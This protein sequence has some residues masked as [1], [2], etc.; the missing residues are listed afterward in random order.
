MKHVSR[1]EWPWVIA[2]AVIVMGLTTVPYAAAW[3]RADA[4]L[5]FSGFVI[6]V[7][8]GNSY[9]AKMQEG[10][11]G[12]WL[13]RLSYAVEDH[14]PSLVFLFFILLGKA[15]GAAAGTD[16]P[17][18]LHDA[19]ALGFHS[20]RIL[21]G[22]G[23]T[24]VTYLFLAEILPRVRQRR[25]A[26]ITASL[27]GGLGWL[28]L[29]WPQ[30]G[31]PL[32]FYSP[33]AFS[34]LHLYLLP[35][36]EAVRALLLGGLLCYLWAVRGRWP[37][38]LGAGVCWLLMTLVQPFYMLIVFGILGVHVA[39]LAALAVRQG[40]GELTHGVDAGA[41]AVRALWVSALSGAFGAPMVLYTFLL[42]QV[43]PV[44]K[45]WSSQNIIL[46]P[47]PWHYLSAWGL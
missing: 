9:L 35:H 6:G 29:A 20:A 47:A 32:E 3:L 22:I 19:L 39:V 1:R 21:L 2:F 45:V 16:D 5:H 4:N 44:Y 37:W 30:L 11:H 18:R 26:L 12:Q 33:E 46:S 25:L 17:V 15:I 28:L 31:Q 36:L 27:C 42:F 23:Q 13:F 10:A 14:P 7:E 24:L 41:A 43:D 40:E 34:F 8:D 38:A